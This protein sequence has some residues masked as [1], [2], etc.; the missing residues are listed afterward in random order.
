MKQET[1]QS[2]SVPRNEERATLEATVLIFL[3]ND[4]VNRA[5]SKSFRRERKRER[6][7]EREGS[8]VGR[9]RKKKKRKKERICLPRRYFHGCPKC[10]AIC[11][12]L[13]YPP[14]TV[15]LSPIRCTS[16]NTGEKEKETIA[17]ILSEIE[18][19]IYIQVA[20][21]LVVQ[22]GNEKILR[23]KIIQKYKIRTLRDSHLRYSSNDTVHHTYIYGTSDS[24]NRT[25]A[26]VNKFKNKIDRFHDLQTITVSRRTAS[27]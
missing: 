15:Y 8:S 27:N 5:D 12:S 24:I 16:A 1:K 25:R 2:F 7:R 21:V 19:Y 22:P 18:I 20:P 14:D 11:R 13:G 26:S 4:R 17:V 10:A 3:G 9:G 23:G 6:E